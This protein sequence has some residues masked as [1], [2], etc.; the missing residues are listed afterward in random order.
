MT[1]A[2]SG[3]RAWLVQRISA[4]YL[5]VFI[6]FALG[7]ALLSP[8]HSYQDWRGWIASPVI[9][10]AA[11]VFFAALLAH[12]WV[13]LRDVVLDYLPDAAVRVAALSALAIALAATGVWAL[14]ILWA[15]SS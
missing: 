7:H 15:A 8:P 5:L 14:R 11:S 9:S 10:I 6:V 2:V 1:R 12:A 3:L 4:V 13:G